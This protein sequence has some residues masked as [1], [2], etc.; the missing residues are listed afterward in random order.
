MFSA[1]NA[2][3]HT[4]PAALSLTDLGA[5]EGAP[6]EPAGAFLHFWCAPFQSGDLCEMSPLRLIR[7]A[8]DPH[9]KGRLGA[10]M[11]KPAPA[12]QR[13]SLNVRMGLA[14]L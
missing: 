10:L 8:I 1:S 3:T 9:S 4:V 7:L 2:E 14:A 5:L 12:M 11:G 6:V 13:A